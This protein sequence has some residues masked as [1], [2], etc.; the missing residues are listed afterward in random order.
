MNL[1]RIAVLVSKEFRYSTKNMVIF[2]AIIV[3]VVL[4]LMISLMVGTLFAG[5]PRLGIAD[6]GESRLVENMSEMDYIRLRI[7]QDPAVLYEDVSIGALDMGIV[8]PDD[9]DNALQRGDTP[10][11]EL[12]TW[13][14]SLLRHRT[15]LGATLVRQVIALS[16]MESP[17]ETQTI[18]LGD[19]PSVPWDVRLFPLVMIM[20]IVLGGTMV[21][22]TFIVQEK[23]K[24]TLQALLVSPV[25][26]GEAMTAKGIAGVLISILMGVIILTLNA[27]W[28]GRP[29]LMLILLV[30][31]AMMAS[32]GG[33]ILGM[34]VKDISTLFTAI[35]SIGIL[36][37]APAIIYIFPE[38]PSWIMRVFPTYYMIGPIVEVSLNNAGWGVI[39][40][41]VLI[42][43]TLII[44]MV[45][46][47]ALLVR[48]IKLAGA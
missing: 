26:P 46:A 23:Q 17:V 12:Y 37:Y 27:A 22:A 4:S 34:R 43:C 44:G 20:T 31:S 1:K 47:A 14:E 18:L 42:L 29:L 30:L 35:K 39:A 2:F 33:V 15:T 40:V 38:V 5:R 36:L 41:D 7:Y 24:R 48:R 28:S 9:F 21:P 25:T 8:L 16:G 32:A 45:A 13:G 11:L 3:P 19:A 10:H 6:L